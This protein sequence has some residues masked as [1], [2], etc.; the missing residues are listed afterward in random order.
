VWVASGQRARAPGARRVLLIAGI[1][2]VTAN[3][4]GPLT[5]VGPLLETIR[6]ETG[7][8]AAEAG[9]LPAL[10]LLAFALVSPSVSGIAGRLGLERLLWLAL[11]VLTAGIVM[12]S[13]PAPGL[14]WAGTLLLGVA[15]AVGNV[16]MPSLIKRDFPANVG[17]MTGVYSTVMSVVG[18][19][20]SGLAVPIAE[21]A[22]GGWR[23][24]LAGLAGFVLIAVAVWGPQ[25]RTPPE[26]AMVRRAASGPLWRSALAWQVTAYMGLQSLGFYV[27]LSWLPSILQSQ[28]SSAEGAGWALFYLQVLGVTMNA[29]VPLLARRMRDQRALAAGGSLLS[30]IGYL[31]L[32]LAPAAAPLWVTLI[33]LATGTCFVLALSFLSLRAAD[34]R[35]AAALSGMAQAVGYSLAAVGPVLFGALHD[36]TDGWTVPLAA[37]SI[38]AAAQVIA[39]FGA[40]RARE[41]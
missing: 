31:G 9:L 22:P 20:V 33:G 13:V 18:A 23:G 25:A 26:T 12:R 2:L 35:Q 10:P 19:V 5:M 1:V 30:L 3:L 28:G 38:A 8:S 6:A 36:V 21:A 11:V 17:V 37:L 40:G 7:M 4:R 32:M 39:G 34:A 29:A 41:I 27:V 15:I 24:A 14:L 16:L